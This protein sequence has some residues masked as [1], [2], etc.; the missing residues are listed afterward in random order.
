MSRKRQKTLLYPRECRSGE[1]DLAIALTSPVSC[2]M[3]VYAWP[4]D[5]SMEPIVGVWLV[6]AGTEN[7]IKSQV[8]QLG[9]ELTRAGWYVD[10]PDFVRSV[11][12]HTQVTGI[13][14]VGSDRECV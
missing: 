9:E 11:L 14:T 6:R 7:Q 8:A 2:E 5:T 13:V 12:D 10:V 4:A 3:L 1:R